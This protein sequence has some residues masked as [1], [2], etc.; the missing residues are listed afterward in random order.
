M[1]VP[2]QRSLA[3]RPPD[4]MN[5][6]RL[7]GGRDRATL[8]H[9]W[10]GTTVRRHRRGCAGRWS[11]AP[12]RSGRIARRRQHD[13][14]RR[15]GAGGAGQR[16]AATV[17]LHQLAA[18]PQ[19]K[20]HPRHA[21]LG[22]GGA[23]KAELEHLL[24]LVLRHA[25]ATI[26]DGQRH[27]PGSVP[28]GQPN[29]DPS[30]IGGE[31]RRVVYEVGQHLMHLVVVGDGAR[32]GAGADAHVDAGPGLPAEPAY[33]EDALNNVTERHLGGLGRSRRAFGPAVSTTLAIMPS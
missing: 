15:A 22:G 28:R 3:G 24:D 11:S 2:W 27:S 23:A 12:L 21:A 13:G 10:T 14:D 4:S 30:A 32:Q 1:L 9:G 17:A 6:R 33:G 16:D 18:D 5:L 8:Y 31:V 26:G 29:L 20:T 25:A 7:A 19:P